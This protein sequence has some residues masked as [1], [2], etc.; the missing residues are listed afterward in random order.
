M[1]VE[2]RELQF[3]ISEKDQEPLKL[4]L[5]ATVPISCQMSRGCFVSVLLRQDGKE[6]FF[7]GCKIDFYESEE[8]TQKKIMKVFAK[9]DVRNRG[10]RM[11]HVNYDVSEVTDPIDWSGHKEIP[12]VK[13]G[14]SS[15]SAN[16]GS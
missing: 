14:S 5:K 2:P 6:D 11:M 13:V 4:T 15:Q 16:K 10:N 8:L 7:D 1:Q 9:R 3:T 12:K